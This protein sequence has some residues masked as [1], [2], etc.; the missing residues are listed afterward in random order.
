MPCAAVH[1]RVRAGGH[2]TGARRPCLA[3]VYQA[4]LPRAPDTARRARHRGAQGRPGRRAVGRGGHCNTHASVVL[5]GAVTRPRLPEGRGRWSTSRGCPPLRRPS[6]ADLLH[7]R[8]GSRRCPLV[9]RG[10]RR[11]E[12]MLPHAPFARVSAA[13]ADCELLR[14]SR[15]ED[16]TSCSPA[17][18]GGR[19]WA[20]SSPFVQP[21]PSR[22]GLRRPSSPPALGGASRRRAGCA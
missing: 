11:R 9:L 21:G 14:V 1:G 17:V 7:F 12:P 6:P 18:A 16:P 3:S 2:T 22:L 5:T 13:S 10:A 15:G 8:T 20:G 19:A 4:G